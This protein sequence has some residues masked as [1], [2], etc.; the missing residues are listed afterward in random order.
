V[1]EGTED[2]EDTAIEAAEVVALAVGMGTAIKEK[3]GKKAG[4]HTIRDNTTLVA[5]PA[6]VISEAAVVVAVALLVVVV[7]DNQQAIRNVRQGRIKVR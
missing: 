5:V 6:E 2:T 3:G 7:L 1:V 4:G